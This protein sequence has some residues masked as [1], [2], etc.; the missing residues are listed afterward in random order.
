MN[1]LRKLIV[2]GLGTGYLPVAPGCWGSAAVCGLFLLAAL[3]CGG[4]QLR[5]IGAMVAIALAASAGCVALGRFAEAAYGKRD[6]RRCTLDEWA[7]QCVALLGVPLGA[8]TQQTLVVAAVSFAAFRFFDIL[9]PPPIRRLERLPG[10]W[11]V[12][13]DDLAA[14]VYAN[15]TAQLVL[16]LA[17]GY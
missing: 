5:V 17:L 15:V 4:G 10:G 13:A 1:N 7:G 12:L 6:P 14:A 11:G 3:G 8:S 16:R 2:T 9:K